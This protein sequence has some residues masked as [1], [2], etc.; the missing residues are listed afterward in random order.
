[1][2]LAHNDGVT[3]DAAPQTPAGEYSARRATW[4]REHDRRSRQDS[5][6]AYSR[7]ATFA[8]AVVIAVLAW[9]R[10]VTSWWLTLPGAVFAF[11][12]T[13]HDRVLRAR[14][15]AARLVA[16]YDHGLARLGERWAGHGEAGERFRDDTHPYATDLDLFGRGSLFELLSIGRTRAGEETLAAWLKQ[17]API[18]TVRGRHDALG[19]LRPALDLREALA[20]AGTDVRSDVHPDALTTWAAGP[21]DFP[22]RTRTALVATLTIV[23]VALVTA[24]VLANSLALLVLAAVIRAGYQHVQGDNIERIL[25]R[26]DGSM[27]ELDVLRAALELLERESFRA[28]A[29]AELQHRLRTSGVHA[30]AAIRRLSRYVE[31]HG[32]SHNMIFTPI[33][34][35]L[36]WN[37]HLAIAVERWRGTYGAHIESWLL[38]VGE[39]EAL[40]S[41]AAYAYEHP[42]DPL[43]ELAEPTQGVSRALLVGTGLGHPLLPAADMVRNDVSLGETTQLLV[44]S[45]SN[46]SGK[47]TLLRTVGINAVLALAGAPVRATSLRISPLTIGATLRIQDSLQEGRS[48]FFAEISRIRELADMAATQP[49]LFLLDELFHGTNSHDRL[50]GAA[51]V[52]RNLVT[53]GAIGLITTHDLALTAVAAD[54][55]S[56]AANVHFE[57]LFDG[58]EMRFDYRMKAGP[59]TRSNALALMRAVGLDVPEQTP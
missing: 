51:G 54:L 56:R 2:Q 13:S 6:L 12:L 43:P 10:H 46:M 38:T 19:E 3:R 15:A 31:M 4:L 9:N 44:V 55:G 49:L 53:H 36:M 34:A 33:A 23:M 52:L 24:A 18:A 40:S 5:H 37:D 21:G 59:V 26:A 25:R 47:S 42:E 27:R 45:G 20:L 30:S 29:L 17:P 48:R 39:F 58:V 57:D 16:F 50:Q 28:P 11:L 8:T 22:T 32:W 14:N 1:M 35:V 7:L 41:L